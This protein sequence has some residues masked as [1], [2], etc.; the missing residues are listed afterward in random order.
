[1]VR[2]AAQSTSQPAWHQVFIAMLPAIV[3][4][5]RISF[6][7]LRPDARAEAI[8][9]AVCNACCAVA[10]LAELDKLD[11][12]YPSPL[13]RYAVAQVRDNRTVGGKL[14]RRDVL[15]PYCQ[16]SSTSSL[17]S[18]TASMRRKASGGKSS[19]KTIGRVLP[20]RPPRELTWRIGSTACPCT[21]V[22]SR[23][24]W[25]P[26]KPRR[27]RPASSG[28]APAGSANCGESSR[29]PGRI[30]RASRP[31]RDH[32][33]RCSV[34]TCRRRAG[35]TSGYAPA[36][37]AIDQGDPNDLRRRPGQRAAGRVAHS[38]LG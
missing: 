14:N 21:S 13:A 18:S 2:T 36:S 19:S 3:T 28:S 4:H 23:R 11:L 27:R 12:A 35:G 15:S 24:C 34:P 37:S 5:A 7:H 20:K 25:R 29:T 33:P 8:Q 6:R 30:S 9:E 16:R 22:V 32:D 10:R 38:R 26:A 31:S 1:M 17:N